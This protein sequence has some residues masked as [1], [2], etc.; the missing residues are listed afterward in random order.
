MLNVDVDEA[1]LNCKKRELVLIGLFSV[2]VF[3]V[4]ILMY[5]IGQQQG[6]EDT[7]EFSIG[8]MTAY[9]KR[10]PAMDATPE[11]I[12]GFEEFKKMERLNQTIPGYKS[13]AKL[14]ADKV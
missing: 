1:K 9:L 14:I 7:A 4:G 3:F 12:R 10:E 6:K 5:E 11:I 8:M 2:L 13:M